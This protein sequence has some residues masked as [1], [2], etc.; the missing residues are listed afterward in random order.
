MLLDNKQFLKNENLILS[1]L[2]Y[3]IILLYSYQFSQIVNKYHIIHPDEYAYYT[4][5]KALAAHGF[6]QTPFS[7]DGNTS[8]IGNFG[9]HG[10]S[11]T[12]KNGLLSKLLFQSED[13]PLLFINFLTFLATLALIL[14][15]KKIDLNARLK[16]GLIVI[17]HH[18]LYTYTFSYMQETIHYF[19]A[20]I[21]VILLY[22]TYQNPNNQ[23]YLFYYLTVVIIGISFRYIWAFWGL[24]LLPLASNRKSFFKFFLIVVGLFL[25]AIMVAKYIYA[26]SPYTI[27]ALF[28]N[29]IARGLSLPYLIEMAFNNFFT[30]LKTYFSINEEIKYICNR[31]LLLLLLIINTVYAIK[32][33]NKFAIGCTLT[34]WGYLASNMTLYILTTGHDNR[35]LDVLIP[36]LA[37]SLFTTIKP[38]VFYA[39]LLVQLF[40]LVIVVKETNDVNAIFLNGNERQRFRTEKELSYSQI[41][42]LITDEH[43]A[44][45]SLPGDFTYQFN[46]DYFT[47]FPLI[48][49]KGYPIHYLTYVTGQ[50]TRGVNKINYLINA[51]LAYPSHR[52][53]MVNSIQIVKHG[54]ASYRSQLIYSD[55]WLQLYKVIN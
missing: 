19:L 43:R 36:L 16:I 45:I 34:A 41:G 14:L 7:L 27:G 46:P 1:V 4:E 22:Q 42:N 10:I 54:R 13:P 48:T 39:V 20:S 5:A 53:P 2:L 9:Y 12:L 38:S 6:L 33:R 28:S 49:Q 26:P 21:A 24:A 3:G 50:D 29:T 30:N 52:T 47:K 31:Y 40:V 44:V 25:I 51:P 11:Y 37:F 32:K 55:R 17:T 15:Y 35:I 8:I 23:K 18:I